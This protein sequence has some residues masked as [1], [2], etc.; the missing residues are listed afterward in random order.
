VEFAAGS[1]AAA[2]A[3]RRERR[4]PMSFLSISSTARALSLLALAVSTSA[5]SQ[6]DT[7]SPA[8]RAPMSQAAAIALLESATIM[9]PISEKV[10]TLSDFGDHVGVTCSQEFMLQTKPGGPGGAGVLN[11]GGSCKLKLGATFRDCKTSGCTRSGNKCTPLV[12]SGGCE[13]RVQC[14]PN[15]AAELFP[16]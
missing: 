7:A 4:S 6:A 9:E 16:F 11:C 1:F 3:Q 14:K 15:G 10:T 5:C 2:I 13:L 12:C 8:E